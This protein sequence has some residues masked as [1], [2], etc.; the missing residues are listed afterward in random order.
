MA[1]MQTSPGIAHEKARP[2]R[3]LRP[4]H[5]EHQTRDESLFELQLA[6]LPAT[7]EIA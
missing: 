3:P 2:K 1:I 5:N 7:G 6:T 4:R